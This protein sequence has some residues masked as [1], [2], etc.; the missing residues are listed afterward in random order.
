MSDKIIKP[1]N[2]SEIDFRLLILCALRYAL[3][4]QTYVPATIMSIIEGNLEI[5]SNDTLK[6]ICDEIRDYATVEMSL[7]DTELN[8]WLAFRANLLKYLGEINEQDT[9]I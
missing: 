8:R 9:V 7:R 4:R 6:Q 3:G 5:T 2:I 1:L